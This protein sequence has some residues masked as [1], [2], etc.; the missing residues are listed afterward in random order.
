MGI[1]QAL[2][3]DDP[4]KNPEKGDFI[5]EIGLAEGFIGLEIWTEEFT[6]T[7]FWKKQTEMVFGEGCVCME[8]QM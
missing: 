8:I 6:E 5:H 1:V 2:M 3:N 4:K 7:W